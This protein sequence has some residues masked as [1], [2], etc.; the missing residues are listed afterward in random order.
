MSEDEHLNQRGANLDRR[1]IAEWRGQVT[2]KLDTIIKR[3]ED[4]ETRIRGAEKKLYLF[5]G[6][7]GLFSFIAAYLGKYGWPHG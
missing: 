2:E 5:S 6:A 7:T 4:H 1:D 3:G